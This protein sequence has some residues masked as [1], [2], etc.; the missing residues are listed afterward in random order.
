MRV[1]QSLAGVLKSQNIHDNSALTLAQEH[2]QMSV[3]QL[4]MLG[5]CKSTAE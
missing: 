1:P 3:S 2:P 5:L 4:L